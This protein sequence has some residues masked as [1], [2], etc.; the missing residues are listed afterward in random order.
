MG[1][2]LL[3]ESCFEMLQDDNRPWVKLR[4][5]TEVGLKFYATHDRNKTE[6][7]LMLRAYHNREDINVYL[8]VLLD[9]MKLFEEA[10]YESLTRTMG[11]YLEG[12]NGHLRNSTKTE[13]EKEVASRMVCTNNHAEGPFWNHA[14]IISCTSILA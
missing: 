13:W 8:P 14:C 6:H 3:T 10:I 2:L 9:I 7:L 1:D 11:E 5:E 12:T 4:C